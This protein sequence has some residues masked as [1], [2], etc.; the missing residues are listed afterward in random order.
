[1]QKKKETQI[2]LNYLN[3]SNETR[4]KLKMEKQ[5]KVFFVDVVECTN[6][7]HLTDMMQRKEKHTLKRNTLKEFLQ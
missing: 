3:L 5:S 4:T 2:L 1:M 6:K 7:F